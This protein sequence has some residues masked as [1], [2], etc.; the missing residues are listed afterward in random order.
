MLVAGE[1]A[2]R[3]I[4]PVVPCLGFT[5]WGLINVVWQGLGTARG[6][7]GRQNIIT[8]NSFRLNEVVLVPMVI[9]RPA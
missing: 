4:V 8:I 3:R 2:S 7:H 5:A 1:L 6:Q 9:L